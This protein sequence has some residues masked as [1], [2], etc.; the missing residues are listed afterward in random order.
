MSRQTRYVLS[1]VDTGIP[2]LEE[3]SLVLFDRKLRELCGEQPMG[4]FMERYT[5]QETIIASGKDVWQWW[6]RLRFDRPEHPEHRDYG[7]SGHH[8]T[9]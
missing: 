5:I 1:E 7:R 4:P 6:W 2:V 9:I 8:L 3:T